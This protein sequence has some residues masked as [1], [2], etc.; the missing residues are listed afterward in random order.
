MVRAVLLLLLLLSRQVKRDLGVEAI[1]LWRVGYKGE[2]CC[3]GVPLAMEKAS[4]QHAL[5][6]KVSMQVVIG[7]RGYATV[8]PIASQARI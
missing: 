1:R 8:V 4:R 2:G 3:L 7:E 5:V 6:L